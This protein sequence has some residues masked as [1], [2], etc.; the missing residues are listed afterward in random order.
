MVA[1]IFLNIG[2]YMYC[3]SSAVN[4]AVIRKN[5]ENQI[6]ALQAKLSDM[7]SSYVVASNSMTLDSA[8]ELGLREPENKIFISKS[9]SQALSFGR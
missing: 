4:Y 8:H 9:S 2:F 3:V 5:T 6:S 7:E 1:A